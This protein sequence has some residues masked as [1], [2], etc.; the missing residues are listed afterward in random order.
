MPEIIDGLPD[1][2]GQLFHNP[3]M[4]HFRKFITFLALVGMSGRVILPALVTLEIEKVLAMLTIT[5]V[6]QSI[7]FM[8]L[9]VFLEKCDVLGVLV[10]L[11]AYDNYMYELNV[12]YDDQF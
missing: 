6:L 2:K 9:A 7:L 12:C 4:Q 11:L 3:L 8:L 5:D 1:L 10:H